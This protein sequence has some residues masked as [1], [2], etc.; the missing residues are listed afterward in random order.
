MQKIDVTIYGYDNEEVKN[1][2]AISYEDVDIR[3]NFVVSKSIRGPRAPIIKER[4]ISLA[5]NY[6]NLLGVEGQF[7]MDENVKSDSEPGKW[8]WKYTM[9]KSNDSFYVG[10]DRSD[11]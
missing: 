4:G 5:K 8:V 11:D 1:V 10:R 3:I 2:L 6:L 9:S 7:L